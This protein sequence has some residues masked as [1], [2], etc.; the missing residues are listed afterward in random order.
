MANTIDVTREGFNTEQ[1]RQLV[2][3]SPR[4]IRYWDQMGLVKPSLRPA[5]G[6]GSRRL[7]SYM[8]LLALKTVARFRELNLSLQ[9][10][11]RCVQY[12]R[13]NLPSVTQP[14]TFCVLVTDGETIY[15]LRDSKTLI[16]TVKSQG[17]QAFYQL[18]IAALEHDLRTRALALSS[19]RIEELTVGSYTYQM[20]I[21]PDMES[22]GYVAEVAGLPGCITQ[23]ET[24]QE[25]RDMAADAVRTYLDAVEDLKE[26]GVRL[27][28]NRRTRHQRRAI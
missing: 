3:A 20:E 23:G 15:L 24:L 27:H 17:Q 18:S 9:R 13:N 28:L 21:E 26:R 7:Y 2:E 4:Q 25:V 22:G 14:L 12:L 1:A 10:I 11:R 16:D 6:R 19:K 8:D 5:G